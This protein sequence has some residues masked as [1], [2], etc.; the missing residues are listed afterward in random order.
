MLIL[1]K[2]DLTN[3]CLKPDISKFQVVKKEDFS[4]FLSIFY[5]TKRR[6][7]NFQDFSVF[8]FENYN[9]RISQVTLER[10]NSSL[11]FECIF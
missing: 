1:N 6:L 11:A 7:E 3:I 5:M 2:Q 8:S 9:F 4:V 10:V